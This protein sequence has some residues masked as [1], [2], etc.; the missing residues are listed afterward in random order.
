MVLERRGDSQIRMMVIDL[1]QLVPTGH[2]LR[3]IKAKIDF[4]FIYKKI[5]EKNL[6]RQGGRPSVDPVVLVRMWLIGYLYG[7]TSERRLEQEV[8]L[9]LAY[10]WFLGIPLDERVPDHSTLSVNRNGRFKD[11]TLFLD[12]FEGIIDQCKAAG[13]VQGQATVTDSTH[14]KANASNE[15]G[16]TVTVSKTPRE[17]LEKLE[18]AASELNQE[19]R[20]KRGGSKRGRKGGGASSERTEVRSTTDPDAGLLNRPGK[21]KGFHYLAHITVEPTHGIILDA[22]ATPA[23]V[24]DHMPYVA[25]I[26]RTKKRH[27]IREAAA[28]AGYDR[29]E[30][31]HELANI[32]VTTYT[33][34]V[35]HPG[36]RTDR[37]K[38]QDFVYDAKE[39]AYRCPAGKM[40]RFTYVCAHS[41]NK[42]YAARQTECK[43]C[44][45]RKQ[46]FSETKTFRQLKRPFHQEALDAA[47]IRVGSSR[48]HE[49][50]R[51]RRVWCEGTNAILKA[52]H[53]LQRAMRRG[54]NKM[55]EQLLM[56][57]TAVNIKRMVAAIT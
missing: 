25:C 16:E 22:V 45:L 33:P 15:S 31:H 2:L 28:D 9:N 30:V 8:H 13:L 49:L 36:T 5:E 1:D 46:C 23:N 4:D 34:A 48:Y 29:A 54:L 55:Q 50:Q 37:F 17:Y 38:V 19:Q 3:R 42:I 44:P 20:E 12:I 24:T 57:V 52:R 41:H 53:C 21:P 27:E 51:Q 14:V 10:R 18:T 7:I 39:D 47:H 56:A 40:L 35:K 11:G 6:Y 32:G 43:A 26:R